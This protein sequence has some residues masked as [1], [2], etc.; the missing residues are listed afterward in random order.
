[1]K[2]LSIFVFLTIFCSKV[3]AEGQVF[4]RYGGNSLTNSRGGEIFTDI[5]GADAT[6]KND[7]DSGKTIG[8]GL[9]LKMMEC[10]LFPENSLL[11]EIYVDYSKFSDKQTPNAIRAVAAHTTTGTTTITNEKITVSELAVVVA[12][13]YRFG[14]MGKFRPWIVP[15]GLAFLVNSPPSNT[16]SYLDIGYHL[17]AGAEYLLHERLSLG[18]DVRHT[19]GS[20]DPS[21]KM[22]Y[23][24][25]AGYIGINF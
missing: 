2:K 3:F 16:T 17:G 21:L 13:K 14:G 25:Y 12:P 18:A 22:K 23:T 11:G 9:N 24:S 4:Y 1:M 19:A 20:G 10:P 8:A 15:I 5:A 7:G 6:K